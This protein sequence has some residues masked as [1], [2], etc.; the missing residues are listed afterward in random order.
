MRSTLH[1]VLVKLCLYLVIWPSIILTSIFTIVGMLAPPVLMFV[2]VGWWGLGSLLLIH[3]RFAGKW[4]QPG[5]AVWWGLL[6][7]SLFVAGI[8][9]GGGVA[10]L[11]A[12]SIYWLLASC[13]PV[14]GYWAWLSYKGFRF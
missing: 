12:P 4:H 10:K 13:I 14:S 7:A 6:M 9:Y 11:M 3:R 8:G 5:K 2:L 1:T